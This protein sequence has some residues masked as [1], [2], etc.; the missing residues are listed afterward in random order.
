MSA[1]QRIFHQLAARGGL[2][3]AAP[4]GVALWALG[5]LAAIGSA[6]AVTGLEL[7][8]VRAAVR[9]GMPETI[10]FVP[11]RPADHDWLDADAFRD[12]LS[13]LDDLGFQPV[14]DYRIEYRNAPDGLA[15]V[16]I[17]TDQRVY[18][19]VNQVRHKGQ[20]TRVA[21]TL[22]SILDGGWSLQTTSQD[23][24]PVAVAFLR[25]ERNLWRSLPKATAIDLLADHATVRTSLCTDL[26]VGIG[27]DGTLDGYFRQQLAAHEAGRAAL[28]STNVVTGIA[29]GLKAERQPRRQWFGEYSPT[30]PV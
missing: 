12:A 8:R 20:T 5:P 15:R 19:E 24:L 1:P 13:A 7:W 30:L 21:T 28:R 27:G 2:M 16:L 4:A 23:P 25:S 3:A 6:A 11:S 9:A 22:T 17:N 26:G 14:A 29:R 10:T 18:A